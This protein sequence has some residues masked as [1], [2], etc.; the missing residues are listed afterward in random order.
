MVFR[1][2]GIIRSAICYNKITMSV[3]CPTITATD[4]HTY[5]E[6]MARVEPFAKR[7]HI[8]IADGVFAPTRLVNTAQIY[9]PDGV[10][11]DIHVMYKNPATQLETLVSL[12]PDLVIVHAE[13][14]GDILGLL[15]ELQSF[16]VKAGVALL[17]ESAVDTYRELIGAADHVLLFGGHL[18]YQGG[19]ADLQGLQKVSEVRAINPT[20]ELAW[21][22]GVGEQN[23]PQ[24]AA[25][26]IDVLNAG[27]AIHAAEDPKKAFETL[28]LLAEAG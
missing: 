25:A 24:I 8:D 5:R 19:T 10:V 6:Q 21:D 26:G 16:S 15:L 13:A 23:V 22:G 20:V 12:K 1:F 27:G 17:A 11:A 18:G 2:G 4:S 9:W 28:Q 7:V 3:I 14:E